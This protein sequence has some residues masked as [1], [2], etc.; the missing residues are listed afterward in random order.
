MPNSNLFF[1]QYILFEF[2]THANIK[3][4][5]GHVDIL[6]Q[7]LSFTTCWQ[8]FFRVRKNKHVFTK[9]LQQY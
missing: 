1:A 7:R 2:Q 4:I 5:Y 8:I 6:V 3:I 9:D